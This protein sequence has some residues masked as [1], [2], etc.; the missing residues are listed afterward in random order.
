MNDPH[1]APVVSV[2]IPCFNAEATI[3]DAIRSVQ[4]QSLSNVEI[5]IIDDC[6]TDASRAVVEREAAADPR[7]RL[8]AQLRN[9]GPAAAQPSWLFAMPFYRPTSML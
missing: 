7:V 6:S 1:A 8:V 9:G 2:V 5:I 3:T 4:A